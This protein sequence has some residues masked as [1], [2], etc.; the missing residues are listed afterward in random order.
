MKLLFIGMGAL[1]LLGLGDASQHTQQMET[2][3]VTATSSE[4]D[5][6]AYDDINE[7]ISSTVE[8]TAEQTQDAESVFSD[9]DDEPDVEANEASDEDELD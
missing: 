2:T 6:D 5:N 9:D 7:D 1:L 3:T 8:E 4:T